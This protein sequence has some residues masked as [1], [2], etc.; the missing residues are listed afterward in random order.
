MMQ[1]IKGERG[2]QLVENLR[3]QLVE[4]VNT[5]TA[6]NI[7]QTF[8]CQKKALLALSDVGELLV[9]QFPYDV[10]T[11]GK[12][13]FLP[14]L[15]GRTKVTF[16]MRRKNKILGNVTIVADGFAAPI[17]AGNFVD[18]CIRNFYTGL[19]IKSSRKKVG[20]DQEF[21]V[22]T[23]PILGSFQEG[24]Y[25]PLTAKLRRIPLEIVRV[26]QGKNALPGKGTVGAPQL[27]YAE[28]D[29]N[30]PV[31]R[32]TFSDTP[33]SIP[34][35]NSKSLLSFDIPGLVALNH[36]DKN[37]NGG[38]SEFFS[39]QLESLPDSKR[40]LLDGEYAPFGYIIDGYDLFLSLLPGDIIDATYVDEFGQLNLVK[41][42][43]SS[44]SEVVQSSEQDVSDSP[45]KKATDSA[46]EKDGGPPAS[47]TK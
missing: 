9:T 46:E 14:R 32:W 8:R 35:V 1:I 20:S 23:I 12:Y 10:P 4:L 43:Q 19:P 42:R 27:S 6:Q 47:K 45:A 22:A 24:F 28:D 38:S 11:E 36:P 41:L 37:L 18:L 44:F 7:T 30:G 25:D 5:T 31:S 21:E 13:S 3:T 33:A 34:N 26:E 15:L 40:H 17:T 39:L 16:T 2:E 29:T